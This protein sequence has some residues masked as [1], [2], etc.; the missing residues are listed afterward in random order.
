MKLIR[1]FILIV[2]LTVFAILLAEQAKAGEDRISWAPVDAMFDHAVLTVGGPGDVY[3]QKSFKAGT[4]P[5]FPSV[6]Q[7]GVPFGR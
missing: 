6:D 5:Y 2:L 1:G 7:S 3:F 4:V